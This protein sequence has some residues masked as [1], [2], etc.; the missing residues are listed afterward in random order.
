MLLATTNPGKVREIR[1]ALDGVAVDVRTLAELPPVLE[2]EETGLTFAANALLKANYYARWGLV[3]TVAEDS[4]LVVDALD[5]RPGVQSARYPGDTYPEKFANLYRELAG[6][7]R[8]WTARY[9]C[10]LAYVSAPTA[11]GPVLLFSTEATVEGEIAPSPRGSH[12][13]GYDPI[14]FYPPF[15]QTLGEASDDQKLTV[16]HRGAAFRQFRGWLEGR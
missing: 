13:F 7:R 3:D 15:G 8:P 6:H 4:G 1:L 2:P 12:G 14:F 16:S 9:V 11:D 5:G 10:A